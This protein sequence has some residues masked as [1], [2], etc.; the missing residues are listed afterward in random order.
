MYG[1]E[2]IE[3]GKMDF[4]TAIKTCFSKY[5]D[6]SGRARRSEYWFFYLFTVLVSFGTGLIS[7]DLSNIASVA[8]LIPT[9]SA[10]VRRMHDVDKSGWFLLIPIYNL[11]LAVS[12]SV[13]GP[14]RFGAP[15][16]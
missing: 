6:F 3:R 13:P 12:D 15:V 7:D 2:N 11:I 16:K 9:I 4:G 1:G 8:L 5:V 14:N 10:G